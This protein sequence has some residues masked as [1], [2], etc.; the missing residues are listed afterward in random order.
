MTTQGTNGNG[1]TGRK[2]ATPNLTIPERIATTGTPFAV[3]IEGVAIE[4][5]RYYMTP[6]QFAPLK[7]YWHLRVPA[8]ISL[9]DNADRAHRSGITGRGVKVAMVD[10]GWYKHPY[11]L[12]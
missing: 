9:A 10:S 5:P 3:L 7:A 8:D 2:E 6:S 12:G 11:F 4:E 1:E